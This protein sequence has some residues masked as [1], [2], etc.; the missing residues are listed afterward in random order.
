[1]G[2][3]GGGLPVVEAEPTPEQREQREQWERPHQHPEKKQIDILK[4]T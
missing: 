1:M 4:H 2:T 3:E